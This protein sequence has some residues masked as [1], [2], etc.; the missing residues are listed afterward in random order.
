MLTI[1]RATVDDLDVL[2]PLFEAYREFYECEPDA[3]GARTFLEERLD[4][5]ESTVFLA[6]DDANG[7]RR[8]VGFTQLYP[9]WGS[10]EL[11]PAWVLYDLFVD[12]SVRRGGVGRQLLD[13][14][15]QH[16]REMGGKFV[17]LETAVD[18]LPGQALYESAGWKRDE[19]FYTYLFEL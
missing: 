6:W 5:D 4:R 19:E 13:R 18:N 2:T 1:E 12:P 10:L 16:A 8:A 11:G 14:G 17:L 9:T 7:Q 3:S 15:V